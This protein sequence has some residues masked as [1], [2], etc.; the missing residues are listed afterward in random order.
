MVTENRYCVGCIHLMRIGGVY[1]CCN[2]IFDTGHR[3][4]CDPGE[5]CVVKETWKENKA[6]QKA[7][8]VVAKRKDNAVEKKKKDGYRSGEEHPHSK[9]TKEIVLAARMERA[10]KG[11]S[12]RK[13]AAKYGVA[14]KVMES[15][16]KGKTWKCVPLVPEPQK[17]G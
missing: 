17:E 5:G 9:L 16:I 13:L 12:Y 14:K 4:P 3:R 2:Y 1:P 15:A 10:Y 7:A 6:K 8:M 11:T